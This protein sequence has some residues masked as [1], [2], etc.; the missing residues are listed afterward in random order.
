MSGIDALHFL[1]PAWLWAMLAL[2]LI[3]WLWWQ[4]A[5]REN[6]WRASVDAHLLPHLLEPASNVRTRG[7]LIAVLLAC[8]LA[9]LALAGPAW[10][11]VAQP[12]WQSRTPLVV[13]LD[14]SSA[15][16][17]ADLPPSRLLQ[18]RAKLATLL[19]E[20]A[21]G[22]V[23]LLAFADDAYAVAPLTDDAANVAL[24][25]DSL[26]PDVM[27]I[28]GHRPDRAISRAVDLMRQAGFDHGDILVLTDHGDAAANA[29]AMQAA[30]QGMRVSV[31][32]LGTEAGTVVQQVGGGISRV[33]LDPASLQSLASAGGGRYATLSVDDA[34]LRALG[35]LSAQAAGA[36]S[37]QGRAGRSWEDAG[38]W[39]IPPLMLIAVFAFRRGAGV[40]AVL[41]VLCLPMGFVHAQS[42]PQGTLW[43]RADQVAAQRMGQGDTAYRAGKFDA[44]A[45]A[46]DG[47]PNADAH[48]NLGNALAKQGRYEDAI[49]AY[50]RALRAQPNMEDAIA[51]RKAVAAAMKRKP[52]SGDSKRNDPRAQGK[53]DGQQQQT[54]QSQPQSQQQAGQSPSQQP[55]P[56]QQKQPAPQPGPSPQQAQAN[57]KPQ[58]PKEAQAQQAADAAQRERMQRALAQ[59]RQD[60]QTP[61]QAQAR[62]ETPQERERRLAND[63]WLRRVPDDPGGLLRAKFRLEYERR[64]L[65]GGE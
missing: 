46:Y 21:G 1:R 55:R 47:I 52:P 59:G 64:Q 53:Q 5:R 39:L 63:A 35:V 6:V 8:A 50:D 25:L 42:A 38:Y 29:A 3:A 18:A 57:A 7:T 23:G 33:S 54:G 40:A 65:E 10:K 56:G 48:Y 58:T 30:R 44:A 2:P 60:K 32:G 15:S 16:L 61:G 13:A 37:T 24:F 22:Q 62:A 19:R 31:L 4:R 11:Q 34:D 14:L 36:T 51:N 45:S 41:V 43:R 26:A 17:A 12:A 20:R 9:I 27:P 49:A 28:D